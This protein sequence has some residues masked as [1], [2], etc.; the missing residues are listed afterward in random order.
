MNKQKCFQR[1]TRSQRGRG[2]HMYVYINLSK[3]EDIS[4]NILAVT[5]VSD[6]MKPVSKFNFEFLGATL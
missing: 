2:R 4:N 1:S 5:L 3:V 6:Q